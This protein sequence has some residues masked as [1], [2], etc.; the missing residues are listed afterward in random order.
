MAAEETPLHP[1]PKHKHRK[2]APE[3]ANG[4]TL[5]HSEPLE[6]L[7]QQKHRHNKRTSDGAAAGDASHDVESEA[8][9]KQRMKRKKKRRAEGEG[10]AHQEETRGE[11]VGDEGAA[12]SSGRFT[13]SIAVAGSIVDNAQ[14]FALA[15]RVCFL[16]VHLSEALVG[17]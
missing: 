17:A 11:E 3:A 5:S 7:H 9:G 6:A 13:I 10:G 2:H 1:T 16:D 4:A 8:S 12:S 14:S 15:S